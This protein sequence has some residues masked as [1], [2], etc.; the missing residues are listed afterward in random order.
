MFNKKECK[1]CKGKYKGSFA[2]CP[3]C[4]HSTEK[5]PKEEDLGLLGKNDEFEEMNHPL[6]EGI[7]GKVFNKMLGSAMKMLEKELQK[8]MTQETTTKTN[9]ELYINGKRIDPKNIRVT[10]APNYQKPVKAKNIQNHFDESSQQKFLK[11]PKKEPSTN[12]RRLSN[13]VV[14]EID[15]PGV[16]S[17]KDVSIVKLENSIEIKAIAKDRAYSKLIP[18]DLPIRNFKLDNNK[19]VLELGIKG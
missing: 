9:F 13:K 18:I 12:I 4:G 17:I 19:L 5:A 6:F 14:Y 15:V 8:S 11:L 3:H 16:E 1:N 2:F 7:S 10:Q